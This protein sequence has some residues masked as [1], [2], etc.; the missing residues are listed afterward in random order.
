MP[1]PT[2]PPAQSIL[3]KIAA[4]P[5]ESSPD[6]RYRSAIL[7][8]TL[9][10]WHSHQTGAPAAEQRIQHK[11][12]PAERIPIPQIGFVDQRP[13]IHLYAEIQ[14]AK[15]AH[16]VADT[17][18]LEWQLDEL[19]YALYGLTDAESTAIERSLG[20]PPKT[21]RPS[22]TTEANRQ[23]IVASRG[24]AIYDEKIRK[25]AE[26]M[27]K[28]KFAVIDVYGGDYEIDVSHSAAVSRLVERYPEVITYTVRIGYPTAF[29][30]GL[31]SYIVKQ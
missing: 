20:L 9:A 30:V 14:A 23:D 8:S 13:F 12:P 29:K 25:W 10:A 28:G 21:S 27:D 17:R 24:Q 1:N 16:P 22:K 7:N 15:R 11:P 6:N 2:P 5:A 3:A 4:V 31:R 18:E 26:P 19:V